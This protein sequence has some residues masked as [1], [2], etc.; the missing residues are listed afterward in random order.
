M[1]RKDTKHCITKQ[2]SN[3][4][5]VATKNNKS[6]KTEPP[7]LNEQQPK[8]LSEGGNFNAFTGTLDAADVKAQ[9]LLR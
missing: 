1:I 3:K 7:H 5:M 8:P 9:I 4:P 2:G 6:T